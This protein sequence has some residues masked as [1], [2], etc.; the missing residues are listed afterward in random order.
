MENTYSTH[1]QTSN[2]QNEDDSNM[3]PVRLTRISRTTL[4]PS[5]SLNRKKEEELNKINE[6]LPI[7]GTISYFNFK[8]VLIG[9]VSVGKSAIIRRFINNEFTDKY[10]CTIGTELSKKSLLIGSNKQANLLVWDTCGQEKY[11]NVTRQYFRGTHAVLLVFDLTDHK[12]FNDL[13]AWY[14]EAINYIS[15]EGCLF[16]VLGNKSDLEDKIAVKKQ[17]IKNFVKKNPNIKR[18]FE[19]SALTGHN[20]DLSFDKISQYLIMKFSGEEINR[21][22]KEY[23]ENLKLVRNNNNNNN[24]RKGCC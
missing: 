4:Q 11:R 13:N 17:T 15:V 23:H 20:I 7:K 24:Q 21:N 22:M 10:V 6:T 2:I 19:I 14:E 5:N 3:N 8:L 18:Y 12:S 9:N 1:E 16:F